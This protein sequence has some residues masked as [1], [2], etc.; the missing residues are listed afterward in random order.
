MFALLAATAAHASGWS[1]VSVENTTDHPVLV[2]VDGSRGV[3]ISD[4][5][6]AILR[7]PAGTRTVTVVEAVSGCVVSSGP[8]TLTRDASSTL[9]VDDECVGAGGTSSA[10]GV[11]WDVRAALVDLQDALF[12][13]R[14]KTVTPG[15]R[16]P[17]P[18]L[19][20]L[21]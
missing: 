20:V 10:S 8:V 9:A 4:E 2:S 19:V 12:G 14:V 7:I 11:V 21:E 1:T 15:P 17:T 13:E 16:R 5:D 18:A 3:L 6:D